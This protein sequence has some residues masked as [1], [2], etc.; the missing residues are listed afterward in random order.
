[1]IENQLNGCR[2]DPQIR[3]GMDEIWKGNLTLPA[4]LRA[5]LS[6]SLTHTHTHMREI[7]NFTAEKNLQNFI[8]SKP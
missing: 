4:F 7:E 1:M 3:P 2:N 8:L 6:E 5:N